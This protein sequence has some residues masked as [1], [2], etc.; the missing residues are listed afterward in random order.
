MK[1]VSITLLAATTLATSAVARPQPR[2]AV[3]RMCLGGGTE[4]FDFH[5]AK[6]AAPAG[7]G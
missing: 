3:R 2:Q 5:D 4:M 7:G 1:T 6:T